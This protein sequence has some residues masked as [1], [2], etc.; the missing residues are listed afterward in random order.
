MQAVCGIIDVSLIK[1][2]LGA[3]QV[4]VT[5]RVLFSDTF[6]PVSFSF[7]LHCNVHFLGQWQV[8]FFFLMPHGI[9]NL[10]C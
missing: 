10:T 9:C 1:H 4:A 6:I 3:R 8:F 2:E 7:R 5:A